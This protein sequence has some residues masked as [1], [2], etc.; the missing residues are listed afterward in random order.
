MIL[1]L[2]PECKNS[3]ERYKQKALIVAKFLAEY[4]FSS[5]EHLAAFLGQGVTSASRFFSQLQREKIIVAFTNFHSPRRDLVRLGS[6]GATMFEGPDHET[7]KNIL[8][9]DKVSSNERVIHDL[10]V[11]NAC[12]NAFNEFKNIVEMI[13]EHNIQHSGTIADSYLINESGAILAVETEVSC[14]SRDK[15]YFKL[16][17]YLKMIA[18]KEIAGV[19]FYFVK[20]SDQ[21]YYES[22]FDESVWPIYQTEKRGKFLELRKDG[23]FKLPTNSWLRDRFRFR[24]IRTAKPAIIK[25]DS[26]RACSLTELG[27][28]DRLLKIAEDKVKENELK[29]REERSKEIE[30]RNLE[31]L[32]RL[33]L[34]AARAVAMKA[35]DQ[36]NIEEESA[37]DAAAKTKKG[38]FGR[39][40]G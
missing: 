19:C 13:S 29:L 22:M 20:E 28:K 9:S 8:R 14:K 32:S 11:Q 37:I 26:S 23:E 3:R 7:T 4:R 6:A 12:I 27:Y 35:R 10:L 30:A 25:F 31:A 40:L 24:H 36:K 39:I 21:K 1:D 17:S 38:I 34:E 33:D 15:V 2:R 5:K 16:H 18:A